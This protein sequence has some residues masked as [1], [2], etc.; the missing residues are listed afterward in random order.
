[1]QRGS[2]YR[3]KWFRLFLITLG[4]YFIY[5]CIGQQSQIASIRRETQSTHMQLQQLQQA[6]ITLNEEL[7]ALQDPKYVEKLAREE[8][9]LVKPG[10]IPYLSG[11]KK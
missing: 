1:M 3:V 11:N 8:L 2:K 7:N 5:L 10:E 9:G 4:G 6:N